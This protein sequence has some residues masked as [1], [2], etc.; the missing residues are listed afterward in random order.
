MIAWNLFRTITVSLLASAFLTG[1]SIR[2]V[3][4]NQPVNEAQADYERKEAVYEGYYPGGIGSLP[5]DFSYNAWHMSQYYRY[6]NEE[7]YGNYTS[8]FGYVPPYR[9][10][11]DPNPNNGY[12]VGE[13]PVQ[14]AP[15]RGSVQPTDSHRQNRHRTGQHRGN[16]SFQRTVDRSRHAQA[17]RPSSG[18]RE[19]NGDTR[20]KLKQRHN[21]SDKNTR[22]DED[23]ET[24][25]QKIRQRARQR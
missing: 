18:N 12:S 16:A 19:N 24:E 6:A 3:P 8:E 1:C 21:R 9:M 2:L 10:N 17:N 25:R 11:I 20:R 4:L 15:T 5:P 7:V 23:R 22:M 14:R 13:K